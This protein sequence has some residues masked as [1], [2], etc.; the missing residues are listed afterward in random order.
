MN[1]LLFFTGIIILILLIEQIFRPRLDYTR[2]Q[3]LL[4]W[5]GR[6]KRKFI[7]IM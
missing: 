3:K 1:I 7:I 2:E 6:N 5:Y 4:L